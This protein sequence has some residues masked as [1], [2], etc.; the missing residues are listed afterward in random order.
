MVFQAFAVW[1]HINIFE[2]VAFSLRILKMNKIDIAA[3]KFLFGFIG[4][5]NFLNITIEDGKVFPENMAN[6]EIMCEI[7]KSFHEKLAILASRP[8]EIDLVPEGEF[9]TKIKARI[10]LGDNIDYRVDIGNQE[11]R[12]LTNTDVRFQ[13]GDS[14]GVQFNNLIWY[15]AKKRYLS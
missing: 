2:N 3:N 5:S 8:N 4:L 9:R 13:E 10:F 7:P 6:Q 14:C 15:S 12:I 1:P 11:I